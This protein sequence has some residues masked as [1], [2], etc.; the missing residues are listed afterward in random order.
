MSVKK[1]LAAVMV[2]VMVVVLSF[3][4]ATRGGEAPASAAVDEGCIIDIQGPIGVL[5]CGGEVVDRLPLPTVT[6]R[7]PTITLPPVTVPGPTVRVPG[8]TVTAP[9]ETRT[10]EV[11]GGTETVTLPGETVT[12]QVPNGTQTVTPEPRTIGPVAPSESPTTR[13]DPS[14]DG[15]IVPDKKTD[16]VDL[17][18]GKTTKTEVG[19]G[20]LG[21][22]VL[23]GLALLAMWAGYTLGYKDKER[24]DTNF[25]RALLEQTKMSK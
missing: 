22:L 5:I 15:T 1:V 12:V 8:P 21:I 20:I 13:Q 24:K 11:P 17:G 19:L 14:P 10:V 2:V 25:L 3:G 18:D 23:I 7:G 4:F 9:G 16:S 6:V